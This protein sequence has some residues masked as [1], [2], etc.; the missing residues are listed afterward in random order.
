MA[1]YYCNASGTY[2]VAQDGTD[3]TGSEWQGPYGLQKGID[4]V[5]AGNDLHIKG[6]ANLTRLVSMTLGKDVAAAGWTAG[7][8]VQNDTGDGDDWTGV[9]CEVST[10]DVIVE[11][12][13]TDDED[14]INL[15]DGIENTT[16][17]DTTTISSKSCDGL[18]I[19]T[20]AGS[21]ASGYIRYIGVNSSWAIDGTQAVINGNSDATY[22]LDGTSGTCPYLWW[23]NIQFT[24]ATDSGLQISSSNM[25]EW[26]LI[27]VDIDSHGNDGFVSASGNNYMTFIASRIH[28]NSDIGIVAG[29]GIRIIMTSI[30]GNGGVG[31]NC[32]SN[33]NALFYAS[34][35]FD[36]G[37]SSYNIIFDT[38]SAIINSVVDGT[39]QTSEEGVRPYD[40]N[41]EAILLLLNR[42]TNCNEGVD[43][44]NAIVLQGWNLYH[45]NTTNIANSGTVYGIPYDSDTDTNEYAP[46]ADDGYND[47]SNMDYNLK[48]SRTYNGD[49][50]DVVGLGIGS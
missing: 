42:I 50:T 1:T 40:T 24:G 28:G 25:D 32:G 43:A 21:N 23:Q 34:A 7:D 11:L 3:N 48:T 5:T 16:Q 45:G 6:T 33:G 27:N 19:D 37:N 10:T 18:M 17:V 4:T 9:L 30:Y 39:N 47:A 12:A 26:I 46:D 38:G 13:T 22:C 2:A 36:N 49:G 44:N 15:A 35:V 41:A 31:I 29:N 20:Q 14:D 8:A